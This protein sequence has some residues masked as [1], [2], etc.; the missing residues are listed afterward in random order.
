MP[1]ENLARASGE[2]YCWITGADLERDH[3]DVKETPPDVPA[4]EDDDLDADLV[5]RSETLWPLPNADMARRHWA[6]RRSQ[7][8]ADVRHIHGRP[9]T[10]ETRLSTVET[11][12][13]LRRPD[14]V[15]ELRARTRGRYD[16]EPRAFARQQ[17][18][19]MAAGRA[20]L[21]TD[22]GR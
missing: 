10:G 8:A 20:A 13:M 7:Y 16:V 17:R 15:L 2:T 1:H 5:P 19:M 12:P 9:V 11:G 6:E 14:L 21:A 22:D 4:F 18:R 3:L